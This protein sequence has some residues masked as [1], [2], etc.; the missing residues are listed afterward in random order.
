MILFPRGCF[1][2]ES[3]HSYALF[4]FN[5]FVFLLH[6]CVGVSDGHIQVILA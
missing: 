3:F 6:E 5:Y 1:C 2:L 4:V